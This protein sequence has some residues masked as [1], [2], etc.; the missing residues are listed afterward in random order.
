MKKNKKEIRGI[1]AAPIQVGMPAFI[2]E[3][4]GTRWT[5]TVLRVKHCSPSE[6]R[7]HCSPSEVRFETMNT[8]YTLMLTVPMAYVGQREVGQI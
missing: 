4:T 6:V 1:P 3:E 2:Y 5:T 7:K 8:R